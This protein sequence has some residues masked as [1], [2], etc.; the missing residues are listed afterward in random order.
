MNRADALAILQGRPFSTLAAETGQ[1]TGDVAGGWKEVI[2]SALRAIGT[3]QSGLATATVSEAQWP[4]FVAYLR[5]FGLR[6]LYGDLV[7]SADKVSVGGG[8]LSI[9][10][11]TRLTGLASLIARAEADLAGFGGAGR[12]VSGVLTKTAPIQPLS[13]QTD[14]NARRYRGDPLQRA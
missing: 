12:P 6:Q 4:E 10:R 3:P 7:L 13:G 1:P 8:E 11:S 5:L 14:P 9:D 2:D